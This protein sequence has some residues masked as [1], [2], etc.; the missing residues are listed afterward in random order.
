MAKTKAAKRKSTATWT[1]ADH[2]SR[3]A[4]RIASLQK[5]Q[6]K[7]Q[8]KLLARDS[9]NNEEQRL[10]EPQPQAKKGKRGRLSS[11]IPSDTYKR[12]H[13]AHDNQDKIDLSKLRLA[14]S[15]IQ[16]QLSILKQRLE[17][18]DTSDPTNDLIIVDGP[19]GPQVATSDQEQIKKRMEL[20]AMYRRGDI[21]AREKAKREMMIIEAERGVNSSIGRRKGELMQYNYCFREDENCL[22][23]CTSQSY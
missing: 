18:W 12:T 20:D 6:R 8:E 1:G 17:N 13:L 15:Q 14:T 11:H 9:S 16:R 4:A 7:K 23:M 19:H 5:K 3:T 21:D 10:H 2:S 22:Q